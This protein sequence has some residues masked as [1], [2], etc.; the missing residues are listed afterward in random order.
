VTVEGDATVF[1][2]FVA[3]LDVFDPSFNI[4]LP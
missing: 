1:E 2:R 4:V 3:M